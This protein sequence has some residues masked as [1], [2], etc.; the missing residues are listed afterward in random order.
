MQTVTIGQ[1]QAQKLGEIME[2]MADSGVDS[3]T[4]NEAAEHCIDWIHGQL[5]KGAKIKPKKFG[6][7]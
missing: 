3:I 1:E 6:G 4:R 7:C 2:M 5:S